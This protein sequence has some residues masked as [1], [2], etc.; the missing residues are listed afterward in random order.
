[1]NFNAYTGKELQHFLAMLNQCE[2]AGVIDIRFV[3]QRLQNHINDG[4]KNNRVM[5]KTPNVVMKKYA[6]CPSC[7]SGLL[8][9][10][11]PVKE[12]NEILSILRCSK[13]CGWSE[14]IA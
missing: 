4:F 7:E 13:K 10:P 14:V 9:G 11:Y 3:R 12:G 1:M 5:R 2:S 6:S 8:I